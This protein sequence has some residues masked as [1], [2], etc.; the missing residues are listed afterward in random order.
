MVRDKDAGAAGL[1]VENL[2]H[3]RR[4]PAEVDAVIVT[5][6]SIVNQSIPAG[7]NPYCRHADPV[8]TGRNDVSS[9]IRHLEFHRQVLPRFTLVAMLFNGE[10]KPSKL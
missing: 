6:S 1:Q 7:T 8:V 10:K 3:T 9:A 4:V 2:L 5:E